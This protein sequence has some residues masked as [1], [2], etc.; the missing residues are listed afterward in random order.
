MANWRYTVDI[1]QH[2]VYDGSVYDYEVFCKSRDAIV[3][4]LGTALDHDIDSEFGRI[5]DG[6]ATAEDVDGFNAVLV[7]LYDWAN[8][9]RVWLG[10]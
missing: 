1:K 4:E 5:V 9:N 7:G 2:L 10:L 6:L 8:V 3:A